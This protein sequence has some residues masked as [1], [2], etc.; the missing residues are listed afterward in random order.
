MYLFVVNWCCLKGEISG[1]ALSGRAQIAFWKCWRGDI[2]RVCPQKFHVTH[3]TVISCQ[4][5]SLMSLEISQK[6]DWMG[7]SV[8]WLLNI[9]VPSSPCKVTVNYNFLFDD[10]E[11][12]LFNQLLF[13]SRLSVTRVPAWCLW[14]CWVKPGVHR[15]WWTWFTERTRLST[16]SATTP[17]SERYPLSVLTKL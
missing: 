15:E 2:T 17:T 10:Y 9:L 12:V 16:S 8:N 11:V 7:C 14:R 5:Y 13:Y 1:F 6:A 4:P 3:R